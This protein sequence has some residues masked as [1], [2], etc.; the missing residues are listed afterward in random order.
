VRP[1]ELERKSQN[2]S[3]DL[4]LVGKSA[5]RKIKILLVEPHEIFQVGFRTVLSEQAWVERCIV[6]SSYVTALA[7]VDRCRPDVLV[8]DIDIDPRAAINLV[9]A[10]RTSHKALKIVLLSSQTKYRDVGIVFRDKGVVFPEACGF[11]SKL[12]SCSDFLEAIGRT[13]P[14]A[15]R[16]PSDGSRCM[17]NLSRRESDV[18][19]QLGRGLSNAEIGD[20]LHLSPHTVKQHTVSLYRK[21]GV[22]NRAEAAVAARDALAWAGEL[23][24]REDLV[25]GI[26]ARS[27]G[28]G[29]TVRRACG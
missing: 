2:F 29:E 14:L 6:V 7:W 24:I 27:A 12:A 15:H 10:L 23:A 9:R 3:T 26:A 18:L 13:Q 21:L 19:W 17:A 28:E 8:L 20:L 11:V 1:F 16:G 22:R 4:Q 5:C 25:P